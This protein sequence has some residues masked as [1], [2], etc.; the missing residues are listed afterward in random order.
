M[1]CLK[2]V[3]TLNRKGRLTSGVLVFSL[4]SEEGRA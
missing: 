4:V 2:I 1:L 3:N